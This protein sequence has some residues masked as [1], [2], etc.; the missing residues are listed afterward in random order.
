VEAVIYST[1]AIAKIFLECFDG[2]AVHLFRSFVKRHPHVRKWIIAADFSLHNKDRPFDCFAFTIIPCDAWLTDI[3]R[4]VAAALPRD[5]KKSKTLDEGAIQW[6][7]DPR[8]FH[9][10]ITVNDRPA[11]FSNGRG[12]VALTVVREHIAKSLDQAA[13]GG[14]SG[15]TIK[16]LKKLKQDAQANGFNVS[17]LTNI[18]LLAVWF[19]VLTVLLGRD[20]RCDV[21][22]WFPD[23][24]DMT[25][26]CDHIWY[27]YALW[28]AQSFAEAFSV[29]LRSTTCPAGVPDSSGAKERMWFDHMIRSADWFAGSVA[30]WDREKNLIPG[31]LPKYH[32]MLEDVITHADNIVI[33]HFDMTEIGMT[34]RRI[35]AAR[36]NWLMLRLTFLQNGVQRLRYWVDSLL[37]K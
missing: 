26:Y 11:V 36:K 10:A 37:G 3:E 27:D 14:V 8:R 29:D 19:A 18:W 17:L 35:V 12:S 1:N 28:N 30:A 9:I 34:F 7:R 16:R 5:L 33:L 24:D 32:Q 15:E 25:N 2:G 20:R 23:R 6:L 21:V 22:G 13:S 31:D 4:D